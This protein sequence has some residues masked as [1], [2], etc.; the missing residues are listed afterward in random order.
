MIHK[1]RLSFI[2]H[3]VIIIVLGCVYV[4]Y[5]WFDAIKDT[6]ENAMEIAKTAEAGIQMD[7]VSK[8]EAIPKDILKLDYAVVKYSLAKLVEINSRIEF[9]YL[10]TIKDD[11]VIYMANSE[12]ASTKD[13]SAPGQIYEDA[14]DFTYQVFREHTPRIT[15]PTTNSRG[16]FVSVLVPMRN[17]QSGR[18]IA[19]LGMDYPADE[20]HNSALQRTRLSIIITFCVIVHYILLHLIFKNNRELKAEKNKLANTNEILSQK[21]ELFRTLFEQ[22]P[23]GISFGNYNHMMID[24]NSMFLKIVGR[25]REELLKL[26][27]Q[28]ITH[29]EDIEKD[30]SL[31]EQFKKGE[32]QG[33]TIK[34]RYICPDGSIVWANMTVAPLEIENK[35][36][37]HICI[38]EDITEKVLTKKSLQESERSNALLLANIPGMAYRS[39]YDK[40]WTMKYVSEGCLDLTGYPPESL[41]SG[42]DINFNDLVN[43]AYRE[44]NWHK[45]TKVLKKRGVLKEEYFIK[46]KD[47]EIKWVMEHG[48]CVYNEQGEVTAVEGL[49]IDI[50]DRKKKEDD[51]LYLT[52][53]DVLSG[54]YNR[55]YYEDAKLLMDT[56]EKYPLSVIIGD[57]N[58]LKL[59]N[60]AIGHHEG[61]KLIRQMGQIL[62][63]C[64]R[65]FDVLARTGGDEFSFLLP[66]TSFEEA[67]EIINRIG[68][69]CEEYKKKTSD[70]A[71]HIS[72]SLGCATKSEV[73]QSLTTVI[74]EAEESMYRH[75]LLQSRSLHSSIISSMKTSLFEKSQ[76][77]EEHA[78]RLINLSK[79]IG[80]K[81]NLLEDQ[82]NELELLSTL[83]DIGKIGISDNILNKPGKLTEEEWQEMKKHPEM[84]YRI[85]MSTRELA[86]IAE[87]ILC[88]HE[89]WDGKGYPYGKQGEE[90]PLLSRIL[91]IADSYDAM[92]SDRA[93]RKAMKKEAAMEEI[94]RNAGSQFDP[95]L[96]ELFLSLVENY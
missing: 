4:T 65:K 69:L 40:G 48:Q 70:E 49:I 21:E 43:Q 6:E 19:V 76:E 71:Y 92:T 23:F 30:I 10:Y 64:C 9:A 26:N 22:S 84:G 25:S 41:I 67:N 86:P 80:K 72:I 44:K 61:D 45:W 85:A 82:L 14:S 32:I 3:L 17:Y 73:A 74:K 37:S 38:V 87:Y 89:R 93:Y 8:L 12:A 2:L 75:K 27:W 52:Y 28:E 42:R 60:S 34:K 56:E 31:F 7:V 13:F 59:I 53:H 24:A 66:N 1:K 83:H 51:I 91:S 77:T 54:L 35:N 68:Q 36:L 57:I 33:Y 79:E 5:N 90:I 16:S 18:T 15:K 88:H 96:S 29:P 95:Y 20:W 46:T 62:E 78:Q 63:S 39:Y 50:T 47:G 58:G 55:R 81:L 94:R 11:K